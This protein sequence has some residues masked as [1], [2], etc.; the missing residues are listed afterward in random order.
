MEVRVIGFERTTLMR[1]VGAKVGLS[2]FFSIFPWSLPVLYASCPLH[3]QRA[4][5]TAPPAVCFGFAFANHPS[6]VL[7]RMFCLF[8]VP[9]AY[10]VPHLAASASWIPPTCNFICLCPAGGHIAHKFK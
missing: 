7:S 2:T 8:A 4:I 1:E 5:S 9:S 6:S 3:L 10:L